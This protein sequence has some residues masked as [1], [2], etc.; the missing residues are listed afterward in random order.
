MELAAQERRKAPGRLGAE[1]GLRLG[2][3][4]RKGFF[5]NVEAVLAVKGVAQVFRAQTLGKG[6]GED[7]LVVGPLAL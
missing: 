7:E 4:G 1:K 6:Q 3:P 5:Q 2:G